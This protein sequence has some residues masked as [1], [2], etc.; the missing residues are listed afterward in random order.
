MTTRRVANL[1]GMTLVELLIS[2]V[3]L[4]SAVGGALAFLEVQTRGF[5]AGSEYAEVVQNLRYAVQRLS[6][7]LPT[8]GTNVIQRQPSLVYAGESAIAFFADYATN[9]EGDP[10]AVYYTPDAPTGQLSAPATAVPIPG[11][12]LAFPQTVHQAGPGIMSPAELLI[13]FFAPDLDGEAGDH[14]LF[15]QVNGGAPEVIARDLRRVAG[16][17]F[18]RYMAIRETPGS[19]VQLDSVP[20]NELPVV[21]S[22]PLHGVAADS[23]ASARADSIRGV[24][25]TAR[26]VRAATGGQEVEI[27]VTR[28]IPFPN[29]GL[30]TLRTCGSEPILGTAFTATLQIVDGL[31]L[32]RLD[33]DAAVDETEGERDV[34]RYVLW[35]RNALEVVWGDP[36]RSLP[37]GEATYFTTDGDLESGQSYQFRLAAQDCTPTLSGAVESATVAIP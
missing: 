37:A 20:D 28:L 34:V 13:Y 23:A 22:S 10:S 17:P 30:Q 5:R 2:L 24:R 4:T 8:L 25:V 16:Q 12:A 18:F 7:D 14:I 1:R 31:P 9:L 19:P 26:S 6:Q 33:W 32:I 11:T 21:H 29:A 35:K 27:P 15:R 36:F 3:L